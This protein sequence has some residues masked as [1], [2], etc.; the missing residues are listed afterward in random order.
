MVDVYLH[1]DRHIKQLLA[2]VLDVKA[3]KV[4]VHVKRMGMTHLFFISCSKYEC[5]MHQ[6]L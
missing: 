4:T 5:A 2:S 3:N 1:A 6:E